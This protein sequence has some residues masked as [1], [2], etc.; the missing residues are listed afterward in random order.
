MLGKK[1]LLT[2]M[3]LFVA[4]V[5]LTGR[6]RLLLDGIV[7]EFREEFREMQYMP[8]GTPLK[9]MA[10][11]FDAPLAD[12]LFIKGMIYYPQAL[13][14][15]HEE[16]LQA[17]KATNYYTYE[18]FD[19]ITDL[20]P[21]FSRAYQ[22]GGIFLSSTSSFEANKQGI[23][24]LEKGVDAFTK[25]V[26]SGETVQDDPRWLLNSMIAAIYDTNIQ[27]RLRAAGDLEGASE[28][29]TEAAKYFRRAAAMPNASPVVID[30]AINYEGVLAGDGDIEHFMKASLAV[31]QELYNQALT[32]G[33]EEMAKNLHSRIK[34]AQKVLADISQ[35]RQLQMFLNEVG[36]E[37]MR[38]KGHAPRDVDDLI[39]AGY[40]RSVIESYPLD[41]ETEKDY[42]VALPDGTFKS[43]ILAQKDVDSQ[44]DLLLDT[45]I[46]YRKGVGKNPD[47]LQDLISAKL[48]ERLPVPPFAA[49]GQVYYYDPETGLAESRLSR[50]PLLD[51]GRE[52][53][54]E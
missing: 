27:G 47:T 29:R 45:V 15:A 37:Y 25:I 21:R 13:R 16:A 42:M 11:G 10:C 12:A 23:V 51:L 24:L 5:L 52:Q 33:D 7:G 20:S 19:V 40:L 36:A 46:S 38:D 22:V 41:S 50:G 43:W 44:L 1:G 9:L 35:T 30:A 39:A 49:L 28:A 48:L 34:D 54:D 26:D 32:R 4:M 8:K 6:A 17:K 18:L 31:N 3:A 14:H 53:A 2:V